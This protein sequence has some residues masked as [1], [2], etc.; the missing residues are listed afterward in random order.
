MPKVLKSYSSNYKIGVIDE[1]TITL[2]TGD[3]VGTVVITG[4]LE[5]Q[6]DS[7][8]I[9]TTQLSI[10]DNIIVLSSGTVGSGLPSTVNFQSGIEIERG[11]LPD[12]RWIFDEQI[13]WTLGGLSGQGTF[14]AEEGE[15]GQKLPLNTPGIIA[16][17]N[18][19]I[20][21]SNG[22]VSVTNT[23]NYEEK[24]FNYQNGGVQPT[25]AG[26]FIID[27]DNIPNTKAVTDYI[28]YNFANRFQT[29]IAEG[30]TEVKTIDD[31]HALL[32]IVSVDSSGSSTVIETQG[33]HGFTVSDTVDISG[34]Q[35]NGDPLE[36]LNA[37]NINV[38]EFLTPFRVRIDIGVIGADVSNYVSNS[39]T[40]SKST[41]DE[42]R[43]TF[44]VQGNNI[45]DIYENR[46]NIDGIEIKGTEI[47]T[48]ESNSD[49][50]LKSSGVGSVK[51]D[52]VLEIS[53]SPYDDDILSLPTAP[54]EGI[55]LFSKQPGTGKTGL[56][57]V[58]NSNA[59]DEI[60]S[61]NR[62]LLFSMLF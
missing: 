36:S 52:D 49:L 38:I 56:Y 37:T 48:T 8:T 46:I 3:R 13:S 17:G 28:D 50:I 2:D 47:S 39:G 25:A 43:I 27:D 60:V 58:N 1:G 9:D 55:K 45:A 59:I 20:D 61:K 51:V 22:V 6:G 10:E 41:I 31:S 16:Q 26:T 21:T 23:P 57:Y 53:A 35:A 42:N 32:D 11:S 30:N 24:I 15:G 19:Y 29:T 40:I 5:V 18:F 12:V 33:P 7:T 44:T 54:A 34:I 4:N 14:Y 62:S